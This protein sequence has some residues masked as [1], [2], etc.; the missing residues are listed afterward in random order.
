MTKYFMNIALTFSS[1][2]TL[3]FRYNTNFQLI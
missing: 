3:V 1:F 2:V